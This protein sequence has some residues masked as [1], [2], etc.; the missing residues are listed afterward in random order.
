MMDKDLKAKWVA[1][2]RSDKWRQIRGKLGNRGKGRCCLGV[3]LEVAGVPVESSGL[4]EFSHETNNA[5]EK[6]RGILDRDDSKFISLNDIEKAP[7]K[8]IAEIIER[9]ETL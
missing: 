2:L 1:D 4:D 5:Y 3:L 7:F 8:K 6:V 9:D